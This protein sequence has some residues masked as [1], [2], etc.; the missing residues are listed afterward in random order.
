MLD[1]LVF[2]KSSFVK[3]DIPRTAQAVVELYSYTSL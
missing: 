2:L 3:K 1:V